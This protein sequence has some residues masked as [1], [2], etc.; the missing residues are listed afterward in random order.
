M[1]RDECLLFTCYDSRRCDDAPRF[2][3]HTAF[4]DPG[5]AA[6]APPRASIEL[7]TIA[8]FDES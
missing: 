8:L 6:D 2:T 1:T 5:T 7:R 3:F 4:D